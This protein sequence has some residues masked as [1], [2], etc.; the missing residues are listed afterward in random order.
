MAMVIIMINFFFDLEP[1]AKDDADAALAGAS[2][3]RVASALA[4]IPPHK[5]CFH[6]SIV[7]KT[8]GI[9]SVEKQGEAGS[10]CV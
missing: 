1:E 5:E 7:R 3:D 8:L 4:I 2:D 10:F 6:R 9:D